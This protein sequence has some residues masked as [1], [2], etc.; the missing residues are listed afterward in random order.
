MNGKL[1]QNKSITD[2][3]TSIAMSSLIPATYFVKVIQANK[4]VKIFK[5]IK[6]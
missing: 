4:E 1:L 6:Q 2:N 3:K 5:I